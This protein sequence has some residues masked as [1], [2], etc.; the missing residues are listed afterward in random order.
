MARYLDSSTGIEGQCLG[1]WL[2]AN[3]TDDLRAFRCQFGYFGYDAIIDFET[4][5]RSIAANGLPVHI[6]L[7]A[8]KRALYSDDLT[9]VLSLFTPSDTTT[10]TVVSFRNA[11]FHPKVVQI[12]RPNGS[13]AAV[14][15]SDNLTP[16]GMGINVEAGII[17][18]TYD[19][20]DAKVLSEIA[21][22]IERWHSLDDDAVFRIQG[23][24][25]IDDLLAAR[26]ISEPTARTATGNGT[27]TEGGATGGLRT[28]IWR[29]SRRRRR[30]RPTAAAAGETGVTATD[31]PAETPETGQVVT[32]RRWCKRMSATDALQNAGHNIGN[33]RLTKARHDIDSLTFFRTILFDNADWTHS[34]DINGN[35]VESARVDFDVR[36]NGNHLG[37]RTLEVSHAPHRESGQKN[38]ASVLYWG[39]EIRN[40]LRAT[41]YVGHWIVIERSADGRFTLTVQPDKPAWAP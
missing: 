17:I 23:T 30:W 3:L 24:G 15:G 1:D 14:V 10:L 26:V 11:E 9:D 40:L 4:T 18:D 34:T 5:I 19:G 38:H 29:P 7:G 28:P 33:I 36:I 31:E 6:V 12:E 16:A 37:N 25:D 39:T 41:S 35:P 27:G 32:S 21:D 8:N 13:A 22:S 2:A 20:D